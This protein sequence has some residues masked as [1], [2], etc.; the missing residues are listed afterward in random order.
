[1]TPAADMHAYE[2]AGEQSKMAYQSPKPSYPALAFV[3]S[4]N[5]DWLAAVIYTVYRTRIADSLPF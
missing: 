4:R 2:D 1:M 5:P 3:S